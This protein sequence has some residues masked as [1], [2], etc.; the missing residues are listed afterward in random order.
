M[1][2]TA[3]N[4]G[5][6]LEAVGGAPVTVTLPYPPSANRY[7]RQW[8]GRTLVSA[9]ARAYK[10]TAYALALSQGMRPIAG[11]VSVA[12]DVYRPAKRGDLDNSMKVLLDALKGVAFEDDQQVC[13]LHARRFD[14]KDK[15]RV[16]VLVTPHEGEKA[17]TV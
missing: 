8:Q 9:E 7:W 3:S 12:V 4:R 1:T 14:D 2:P 10:T 15:P 6:S 13:E 11:P 17:R 5:R 16:E